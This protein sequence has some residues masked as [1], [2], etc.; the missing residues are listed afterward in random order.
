MAFNYIADG[1]YHTLGLELSELDFWSGKINSARFD[2]FNSGDSG[3]ALLVKS[4][5]LVK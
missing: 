2:F 4:I 3:D 1:A 5:K